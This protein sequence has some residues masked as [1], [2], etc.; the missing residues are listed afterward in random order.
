G[1]VAALQNTIRCVDSANLK[2]GGMVLQQLASAYSV[3]SED[4]RQL[5]VC[6]VDIGGGTC[7]IIT[8]FQVS[9]VH[10]SKIPVG[11]NNFTQDVAT[12]LRTTQVNAE[13]LKKR[14]GTAMPETIHAD[15]TIEVD[16]VGGHQP[17]TISRKDLCKI[18][19][20][21]AEETLSL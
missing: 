10:T 7:D 14:Y 20:A 19:E 8:Y 17:R 4:E 15:E 21:R 11:G 5:C 16:G 6:L 12:G 3:L 9:V 1:S 13:Q 2:L 18:I